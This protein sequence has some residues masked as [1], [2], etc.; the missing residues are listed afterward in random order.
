[1][2]KDF[3]RSDRVAQQMQREL[4]EL[5]RLELKDPRI[6]MV[7]LTGVEVTRDMSHAKVF[8][9]LMKGDEQ[10]TEY[11]LNRSSGWLRNELSKRIK[12]FKMP[13]LHFVYDRS[14][15]YGMSL[16]KLIDQ[17]M[18]T[19]VPPDDETDADKKD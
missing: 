17:A 2:A 4:A 14:V 7:T 16:D 3:T 15:E 18:Q 9:T 8:Y 19:T 11:T 13:E 10:E 6:G 5:I 1:M 12:L